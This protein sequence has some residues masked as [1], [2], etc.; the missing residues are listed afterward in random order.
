MTTAPAFTIGIEEE[1]LL[2]DPE[3]GALRTAPE[4]LL[5][6][7]KE[8]LGDQVSTEFLGCQVEVGTGVCATV[9]DA[10]ADLSRLRGAV[11]RIARGHGLAPIAA[12]CHPWGN[13]SDQERT[14][15]PRYDKLDTDLGAVARR[16][17]IGGMHVHVGIDDRDTRIAVMNSLTPWLP[18]L[19]ALS[20]SSPF[21]Q[22]E[23][24][25]LASWRVSVFDSMP[26]TGLPPRL[27]DWAAFEATTGTLVDLGIIEDA[28]KIWWDLRPS[29]AFPTLE[30]RI[31]DVSPRIDEALMLAALVQALARMIWRG[32]S[33]DEPV[34][35]PLVLSENRW[36]AQRYGTAEGLIAGDPARIV[37]MTRVVDDMLNRLAPDLD[38]FQ[39]ASDAEKARG[40]VTCGTSAARQRGVRDM[41]LEQGASD[42]EALVQVVTSLID[43][44]DN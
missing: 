42:R 15:K 14:E 13:W 28:S 41:A 21:W 22:G 20:A 31:C 44:F 27:A 39:S 43:A 17:L 2:V 16:M 19:L 34:P 3:S 35:A 9:A 33:R 6:D 5:E 4:K 12:S 10:R 7:L 25:G 30:A 29:A 11:S 36:R 40:V 38:H 24:T 32:M 26:R 23:D 8:A 18:V 37:P 1:Y